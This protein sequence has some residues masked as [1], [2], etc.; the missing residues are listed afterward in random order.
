VVIDKKSYKSL[1]VKILMNY[2]SIIMN[3]EK[4]NILYLMTFI[5]KNKKTHKLAVNLKI[6][7]NAL[8]I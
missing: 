8:I 1:V 7:R 5:I 3:Y 4:N 2:E 6:V